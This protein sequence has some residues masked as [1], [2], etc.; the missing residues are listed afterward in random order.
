MKNI[1]KIMSIYIDE[2]NK[3][4]QKCAECQQLYHKQLRLLEE[5]R[6]YEADYKKNYLDTAK[7]G[8]RIENVK[9][10]NRFITKLHT[11]IDKQIEN[12]NH[13]KSNLEIATEIWQKK[14]LQRRTLTKLDER[15][16]QKHRHAYAL[17]E[18]KQ[19]DEIA[20]RQYR[21]KDIYD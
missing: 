17:K 7:V 2:E 12:L 19:F 11:L 14:R 10:F 13:E 4:A 6:Q 18:Q 1:E 9:N 21:R 16:A 15:M 20:L 3:A 8:I 5:L